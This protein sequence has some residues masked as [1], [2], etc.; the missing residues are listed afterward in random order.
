MWTLI[1]FVHAGLL[2]SKDSMAVTNV[3]GF[4]SQ[5]SCVTAGKA[6]EALVKHTTKDVVF[7]CVEIK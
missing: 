4:K 5:A 1:L 6:A 2:S 3:E 7:T